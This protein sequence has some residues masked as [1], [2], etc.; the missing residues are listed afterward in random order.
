MKCSAK[1]DGDHWILNGEKLWI[2]NAEHAGVFIVHA[3]CDFSKVGSEERRSE[4]W[5]GGGGGGGK[6]GRE[7]VMRWKRERER[8]GILTIFILFFY[9]QKHRGISAFVVD[10]GTPGLSLGKKE[11]KVSMTWYSSLSLIPLAWY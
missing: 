2:T 4:C 1:E 5:G 6:G 10:K 9:L 11:D 7:G 8:G 3:N